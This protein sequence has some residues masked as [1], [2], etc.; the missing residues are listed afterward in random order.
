ME[1][2]STWTVYALE[3]RYQRL[4]SI[5]NNKAKLKVRVTYPAF[6]FSTD[7]SM[8]N[9]SVELDME[10]K[11]LK[12]VAVKVLKKELAEIEKQWEIKFKEE[13]ERILEEVRG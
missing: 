6:P 1:D 12:K 10:E 5:I 8:Q 9:A 11:E 2:Y 3:Q 7:A 13:Q 4:S